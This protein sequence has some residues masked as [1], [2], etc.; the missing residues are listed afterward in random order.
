MKF[1]MFTELQIHFASQRIKNSFSVFNHQLLTK[2]K[3]KIIFLDLYFA[4]K[5]FTFIDV[6][7]GTALILIV[8][9]GIFGAYRLG[10][11]V[12]GLK[13]RKITATAIA[14]GLI[15][16]SR[17]LPYQS[18]GTKGAELPYVQG[19]LDPATSTVLNNIEYQIEN[20]VKFIVDE[21]D[22]TG[23]EDSCNWDYK[24][25]EVKV[26]WLDKFAGEVKLITDIAPKD[27]IEEIQ[28]CQDQ[29]GGILSV[30]VFDAY[31]QPVSFP[32]IEVFNSA[33]GQIVDS[34]TPASGKND[35]PLATSTYKVVISKDGYSSEQTFT[36]GDVYQEKI[37]ITPVQEKSHPTILE[38]QLT[39]ISFSIDRV[40]SFFV[41]TF[42]PL[43]SDNFFDS[44][45]TENK[46]SEKLNLV[47]AGGEIDLATTTEGYYSSGF[48]TSVGVLPIDIINWDNF[49][50]T[51]T[52][53]AGTELKFQIYYA[54]GTDWYLIPDADLPDNSTGFDVSPA[55]LS[56]LNVGTYSQLKLKANFSTTD[57]L[58][59]PT[60]DDWQVSWITSEPTP[61]PNAAFALRGEKIV[62]KDAGENPI[63]KYSQNLT[64]DQNGEKE[65]PNLEWDNYTF[66]VNLTTGLD[67]VS[68]DPPL[69]PIS[70]IPDN[71]LIVKL[72][73]D[74]QNSLLVTIQNIETLEPIFSAIVRLY[75]TGLGYDKIQYTN[76]KG[77]TYFI[78]LETA[79]YNLE[80]SAQG[81]SATSTSVFI[82]GD[83]TKTAKL[84]QIE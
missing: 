56:N 25:V 57:S 32:L 54:S 48:L 53:P 28:T 24:R 75:N 74:A 31:G 41:D 19:V 27:K 61:V 17:N 29:P 16:K 18:V 67:L 43:G 58:I 51:N 4:K 1:L 52:E 65:I 78:P 11:E 71:N 44:F 81:Y 47:V 46:I 60:L 64:T 14:T 84:E 3:N 36:S 33:T 9:G 55:D 69:Q 76:E 45:L 5:G 13:Q 50:F 7:V 10:L 77:Q 82:S 66:S 72:Y 42:S 68:T 83:I 20:K 59:S 62:G 22:G 6:L 80:I 40:S 49:L 38:S 70:L 12:V 8:F 34:S 79:T 2:M 73:L 30:L 26:S 35:F 15:E 63:Y 39:E 23:A 37:I 21:T